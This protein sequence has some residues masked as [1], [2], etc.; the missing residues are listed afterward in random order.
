MAIAQTGAIYKALTFDGTSSRNYGVYIT[1]E[2][3]YN[4]PERAVEMIT[5]PG[6]N[7]AFALDKGHF[8]NIEVSY[9]AGIFADT[10]ADF[11]QAVSDFR[12]FLCSKRG[13]CKLSD[14]YN[15][16]EY[17]MAIYK[18]GLEVTPTMLRAGEFTI[19]FE[20]KPQRF[21]TSGDTASAVTSG[22][23][24][25]NPTLFPS[26]PLLEV[27]GYGDITIGGG[28]MTVSNAQIGNVQA[29]SGGGNT[30]STSFTFTIDN[31]FANTGDTMTFPK[32]GAIFRTTWV[33]VSGYIYDSY[34]SGT[35]GGGFY[36]A[37]IDNGA[38]RMFDYRLY[39]YNNPSLRTFNY[40]TSKTVSQT[41]TYT[42]ELE[43]YTPAE[44]GS[45]AIS[46]AYNGTTSFTLTVTETLPT[47]MTELVSDRSIEIK[48]VTL[49][50]TK[51]AA[52]TSTFIDLAIGEAYKISGGDMVSVNN[53]VS[54]PAELP[55]LPS[56]N[57][58]VTFD[59][60]FS[61]VKVAPRWW[62]V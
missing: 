56:G 50:S 55:T 11:A 43:D 19:T 44:T 28:T 40:G 7:G 6:R 23:T 4:A 16:G 59:N 38:A 62:K 39:A 3:V 2:A 18:S 47:H 51:L 42:F 26:S 10:E 31:Q 25:T 32:D 1:G 17:R 13:Y 12:N 41:D 53:L 60:T 57:S 52:G 36:D 37:G 34:V 5:I 61:T 15:S 49:N 46:L 27:S 22:G 21:L 30:L 48:T 24:L 14:E 9:P 45:I 8:E 58:T 54:I 35:V 33:P 20:C 29:Y